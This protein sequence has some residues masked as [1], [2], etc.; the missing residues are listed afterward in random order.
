MGAMLPKPVETTVMEREGGQGFTVGVA[1]MNGF[2]SKM[3]D[4]HIIYIKE[5]WGFFGVFDGHGGD[6]CAKFVAEKIREKLDEMGKLPENDE[7]V[8]KMILDVD[9]EFNALEADSGSTGAMCIVEAPAAADGKYKLRVANAGDSRVLL[10]KIDGAIVDGGGTDQGLTVDH[11]PDHPSEEA[12]IIRCGGTVA[13]PT[14]GI[15]V[16]RV[17]GDLAVSRGFGDTNL[18]TG[19]SL[20]ER[21]VTADPELGTFECDKTDFLMIVC[22]GVSEGD[23]AN[24]EVVEDAARVLREK[25]DPAAAAEAV[26]QKALARNSK[27]NIT[28]MIVQFTG[29]VDAEK[30]HRF[31]PGPLGTNDEN[32]ISAYKAMA[33]RAGF[34]LAQAVEMRYE[35]VQEEIA[36]PET[37]TEKKQ[38][39]QE[40][41]E[42]IGTPDGAKGSEEWNSWFESWA[43]RAQS[44]SGEDC[45]MDSAGGIPIN[46]MRMLMAARAGGPGRP[47]FGPGESSAGASDSEGAAGRDLDQL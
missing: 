34:N 35:K 6:R 37:S 4:S 41:A 26:I 8:K 22:D 39:L 43:E 38:E 10:G 14:G 5:G 44:Q 13:K 24:P 31:H 15:G 28:C 32:F 30:E 23:F 2:R 20:E 46:L 7:A 3:E 36:N 1:E 27:D 42:K 9:E 21:V 19:P 16:A 40:E 25:N 18:K 29:P 45:G 11:K 47:D 33:E 17:N 12:R